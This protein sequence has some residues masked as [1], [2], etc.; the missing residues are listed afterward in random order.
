M[1][2]GQTPTYDHALAY[3]RADAAAMQVGADALRPSIEK[4]MVPTEDV[5]DDAKK[6][7]DVLEVMVQINLL[8]ARWKIANGIGLGLSSCSV[9]SFDCGL[10]DATLVHSGIEPES[11]RSP[12]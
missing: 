2:A 7:L 11:L 5:G 8:E 10:T 1:R 9:L 12:R 6:R 4:G 3:I